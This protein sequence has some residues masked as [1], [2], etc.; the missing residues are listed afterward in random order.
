MC[1][2]IHWAT[3]IKKYHNTYAYQAAVIAEEGETNLVEESNGNNDNDNDCL[4]SLP[5]E[6]GVDELELYG[7]EQEE[8]ND[9]E[10]ED[11]DDGRLGEQI[12]EIIQR[13]NANN[14]R[15]K[16]RVIPV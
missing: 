10:Q 8:I 6:L 16:W 12:D 13:E 11:D 2:K 4:V 14:R 3:Y 5:G 1:L 9:R 15:K 7:E